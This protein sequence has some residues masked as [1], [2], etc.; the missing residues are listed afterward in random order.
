MM[1]MLATGAADANNMTSSVGGI[2]FGFCV[3]DAG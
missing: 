3:G 2:C 1:I